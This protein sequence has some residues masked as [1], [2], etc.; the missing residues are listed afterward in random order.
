MSPDSREYNLEKIK[1]VAAEEYVNEYGMT[2][3]EAFT[4][5]A[6]TLIPKEY[7]FEF[8]FSE[9][10]EYRNSSPAEDR[11]L[12]DKETVEGMMDYFEDSL[13]I[14]VPQSMLTHI[15]PTDAD[16]QQIYEKVVQCLTTTQRNK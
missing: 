8:D 11:W 7:D 3:P 4:V 9:Y 6:Q 5:L 14:K 12:V 13:N 1:W 10:R 2:I 15:F 16:C